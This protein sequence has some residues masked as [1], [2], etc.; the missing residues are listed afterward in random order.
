MVAIANMA[1]S[2]RPEDRWAEAHT[3]MYEVTGPS[4]ASIKEQLDIV[5]QL[6]EKNQ[7]FAVKVAY[8]PGALF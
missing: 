6:A 4:P 5:T 8:T 3:L 1:N 2:G 7:G